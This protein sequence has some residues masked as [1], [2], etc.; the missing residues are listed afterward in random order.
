MSNVA[1]SRARELVLQAIYAWQ[2][3]QTEPGEG[4]EYISQ[5]EELSEA[6]LKYASDLYALVRQHLLWADEQIGALA[7]NWDLERVATIDRCI[8]QLA[9]VE[10]RHMVD[11]PIKVVMNEAIEMAKKYSTPQSSAFVN[12]ILDQF[13]KSDENKVDSADNV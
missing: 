4:F 3:G 11:V 1:R 7:H 2:Q 13:A 5:E 6:T 9:L 10:L 12:G 8:L